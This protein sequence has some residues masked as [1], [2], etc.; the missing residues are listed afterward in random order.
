MYF[1]TIFIQNKDEIII[2]SIYL[3]E[4]VPDVHISSVVVGEKFPFNF[5]SAFIISEDEDIS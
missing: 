5:T 1:G 4:V 2:I 3:V